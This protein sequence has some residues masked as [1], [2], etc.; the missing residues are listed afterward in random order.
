VTAA[1]FSFERDP[2]PWANLQF[3]KARRLRVCV[4]VV[5]MK[6]KSMDA[7]KLTHTRPK[8]D[9]KAIRWIYKTVTEKNPLHVKFTF[10]LWTINK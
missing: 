10:A 6:N 9:A 4:R 3:Q 5:S 8:L 2:V 7:R 1:F